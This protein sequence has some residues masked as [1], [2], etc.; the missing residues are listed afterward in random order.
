MNKKHNK[1][2]VMFWHAFDFCQEKSNKSPKT[3]MRSSFQSRE[4]LEIYYR[5]TSGENPWFTVNPDL[6]S[7]FAKWK[8]TYLGT[9]FEYFKI[10]MDIFSKYCA[11]GIDVQSVIEKWMYYFLHIFNHAMHHLQDARI[12]RNQKTGF[13]YNLWIGLATVDKVYCN[14]YS[15]FMNSNIIMQEHIL[16]LKKYRKTHSDVG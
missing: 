14:K 5:S 7:C 4:I 8:L 1:I 10:F 16:K 12:S 6:C 9:F 2:S 11:H 3:Q 13:K 15:H